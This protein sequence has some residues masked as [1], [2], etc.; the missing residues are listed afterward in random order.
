MQ[1]VGAG[2]NASTGTVS[3][4]Y[5][6]RFGIKELHPIDKHVIMFYGEAVSIGPADGLTWADVYEEKDLSVSIQAR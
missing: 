5:S 3:R 6:E 1:I 2:A 4:Y